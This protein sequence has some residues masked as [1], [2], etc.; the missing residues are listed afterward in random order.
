MFLPL[1]WPEI[2]TNYWKFSNSTYNRDSTYNFQWSKTRL[3][4]VLIIKSFE[5]FW[6]ST[7]NRDSTYNRVL[8]VLT[9]NRKKICIELWWCLQ[10]KLS[11]LE[12]NRSLKLSYHSIVVGPH[13]PLLWCA[14]ENRVRVTLSY[15]VTHSTK[16]PAFSTDQANKEGWMLCDSIVSSIPWMKWCMVMHNQ[17]TYSIYS[18][19]GGKT[20]LFIEMRL[21]WMGIK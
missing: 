12:R 3:S 16:R 19:A 13:M 14:Q 8:R 18:Y 10:R 15:K 6:N 21:L 11:L 9:F 20:T 7:Y 17:Y 2:M 4:T 5:N 1:L